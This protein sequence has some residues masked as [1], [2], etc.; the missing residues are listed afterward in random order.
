MPVHVTLAFG[1]G[2]FVFHVLQDSKQ[3][4]LR[5]F[6]QQGDVIRQFLILPALPEQHALDMS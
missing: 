4:F 6:G 3:P 2:Q 5:I 1:R